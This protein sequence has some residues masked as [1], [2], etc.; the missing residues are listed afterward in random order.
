MIVLSNP[1][2]IRP[3]I[4]LEYDLGFKPCLFD[5]PPDQVSGSHTDRWR[6]RD[7][8]GADIIPVDVEGRFSVGPVPIRE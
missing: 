6:A 1:G 7:A 3:R 4:F 2:L 8:R 5:P